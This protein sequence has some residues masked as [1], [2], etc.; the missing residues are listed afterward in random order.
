MT[1]PSRPIQPKYSPCSTADAAA[2]PDSRRHAIHRHDAT[3]GHHPG[4]ARRACA[5]MLRAYGG[6]DAVGADD[7]IGFGRR[8]VGKMRHR[9]AVH[10]IGADADGAERQRRVADR[11]PQ[12][13]M[14]IGAVR[15]HVRRAVFLPRDRLQRLAE[16][17]PPL[18]PGDRHD[19]ERLERVAHELVLEPERAQHLDAVRTDL[20]PG[21]D[22]F[23][24]LRALIERDLDAALAQRAGC[25]E[26][27]MP[28][29]MMTTRSGR[30]AGCWVTPRFWTKAPRPSLRPPPP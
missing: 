26:P 16:A 10:R 14:Q 3:P 5:E 9:A 20:Q 21:A 6:A 24:F 27:P 22:L 12:Q 17:Q 2:G 18:V 4:E 13:V 23:E 1:W 19:A 29:P 7:D 28:A 11:P 25:G 30:F 8:A 15:G